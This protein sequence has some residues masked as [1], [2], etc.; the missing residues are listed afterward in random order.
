MDDD[1]PQYA[2]LRDYLQLL[3]KQWPLIL[4]PIVLAV[5]AALA[6]SLRQSPSYQA[7]AQVL[8]QDET[9]QLALL[10]TS[11][12]PSAASSSTPAIVAQTINTPAFAAAVAREL[13]T[14]VP[15]SQLIGD[16]SLSID[17]TTGL[18]DVNATAGSASF[19]A[20]VANGYAAEI[21]RRTTTVV[22]GRL[23][24]AAHALQRRIRQ[25]SPTASGDAGERATLLDEIS[26]LQFLRAT[27]TPGQVAKTA[28]VPGSP[29]SPKPV[30]NVGLALL[31][32][33]LLGVIFAFVR[34]SFDRRL[35]GSAAI[36]GELGLR[37]VGQVR[38]KTMGKA[39]LPTVAADK[40]T[41]GDIETFRIL[42]NNIELL[43]AD[44]SRRAVLVTSALPEE[45]KSTVAASLALA[46]AAA[47]R[48]TLL[49]EADLR[50]PSL[51]KR[52]GVASAPGLT[53]YLMGTAEPEDVLR[54]VAVGTVGSSNGDSPSAPE[55]APGSVKLVCLPAGHPTGASAEL[56]A[57]E[58]MRT[59]IDEVTAVYELVILDTAPLLPVADTLQL[60]PLIDA[61]I[62][63]VKS[64]RTTREQAR[65]ARSALAPVPPKVTGVVVTDL[66]TQD[67]PAGYGLY[68]YDYSYA[69]RVQS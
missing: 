64:G 37:V 2:S 67:E 42:R 56:L 65:A 21:A 1:A 30:R 59:L 40:G 32:G 69:E 43:L 62:L 44:E 4:I 33:L 25:L 27:S 23:I 55:G 54:S 35:R 38:R 50:R 49:I 13:R 15:P 17:A 18:L 68:P 5:G 48:R 51:A 11:V 57:S 14:P 29:A 66:R 61:V 24:S 39:V 8:I 20:T 19:A 3:R 60:L 46:A 36:V 22:R 58:R 31:A 47:G 12:V 52:L 63:C 34:E 45:G 6:Y 7:Q 16:V 41:A 10:G 9:Q 28:T 53:E 26:R